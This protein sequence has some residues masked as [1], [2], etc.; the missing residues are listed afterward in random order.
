ML[1]RAGRKSFMEE[2]LKEMVV[3]E[4]VYLPLDAGGVEHE[5]EWKYDSTDSDIAT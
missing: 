2:G 4:Y 3:D 1:A 5:E